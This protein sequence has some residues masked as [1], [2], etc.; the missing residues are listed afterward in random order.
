MRTLTFR[1][2]QANI[3]I[4]RTNGI[5]VSQQAQVGQV[6]ELRVHFRRPHQELQQLG[7]ILLVQSKH[8]G[9]L[10]AGR[11]RGVGAELIALLTTVVPY[12]Q[13]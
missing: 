3:A 9:P 11:W 10:A 5:S 6:V 12:S 13:K 8:L 7:L 2:K 1:C 4:Q